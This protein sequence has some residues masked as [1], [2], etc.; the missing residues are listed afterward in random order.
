MFPFYFNVVLFRIQLRVISNNFSPT[1][2][3]NVD[4][5]AVTLTD[6]YVLVVD[7]FDKVDMN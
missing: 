4:P 1:G 3:V 6:Y 2:L 7:D 5:N